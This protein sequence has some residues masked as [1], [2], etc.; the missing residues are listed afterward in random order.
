MDVIN[1]DN[2]TPKNTEAI[3]IMLLR[4]FRHKFRQASLKFFIFFC[5]LFTTKSAKCI[6]KEHKGLVY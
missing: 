3:V 6:T 4:E 2:S 5:F 1:A